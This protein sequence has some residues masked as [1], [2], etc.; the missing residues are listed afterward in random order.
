MHVRL[1][2]T[3]KQPLPFSTV[4]RAAVSLRMEEGFS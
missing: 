3:F 2:V 1:I 4:Y